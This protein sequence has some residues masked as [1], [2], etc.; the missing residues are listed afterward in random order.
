MVCEVC[1]S[2]RKPGGLWCDGCWRD[3]F[4]CV[5]L[6]DVTVE[7]TMLR[8]PS[9]DF[10][11]KMVGSEVVAVK[12]RSPAST[13]GLLPTTLVTHVNGVEV[14]RMKD[15]EC[16]VRREEKVVL[17][18]TLRGQQRRQG[19]VREWKD[20]AGFVVPD[21]PIFD[22]TQEG[23]R[24]VHLGACKVYRLGLGKRKDLCRGQRV[25][26]TAGVRNG[27]D[28]RPEIVAAAVVTVGT[29]SY[30]TQEARE[31]VPSAPSTIE[32]M[33]KA[34]SGVP[35][36]DEVCMLHPAGLCLKKRQCP[37]GVHLPELAPR[38]KQ[39]AEKTVSFLNVNNKGER[40]IVEFQAGKEG[41][42]MEYTRNG[43]SRPPF[44][45]LVFD[46]VQ[47]VEM[48]CIEKRVVIHNAK[49]LQSLAMLA[50]E[51]G[52]VHNLPLVARPSTPCSA[53][54]AGDVFVKVDCARLSLLQQ[55]WGQFRSDCLVQ[56]WELRNEALE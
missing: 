15:V 1:K 14:Q 22:L 54:A 3:C 9:G 17:R 51:T 30:D 41:G 37:H 56:A 24:R 36:Q 5:P 34:V 26:F 7:L 4:Q 49:V 6:P 45:R 53:L 21:L 19:V 18:G 11:I 42:T 48:P 33:V 10:G 29:S 50:E 55:K 43:V 38:H 28:G 8:T 35:W 40:A 44:T 13:A 2:C 31:E 39:E 32:D 52:V 46:G 20:G 16:T 47:V 23:V 25:E 12:P 27:D